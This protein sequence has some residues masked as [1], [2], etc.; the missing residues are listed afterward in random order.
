M[1]S[2]FNNRCCR[3][4]YPRWP[5][6]KNF[7][8]LSSVWPPIISMCVQLLF[9]ASRLK[10]SSC[11]WNC[12]S[13]LCKSLSFHMGLPETKHCTHILTSISSKPFNFAHSSLTPNDLLRCWKQDGREVLRTAQAQA[14]SLL[15]AVLGIQTEN[16]LTFSIIDSAGGS[17]SVHVQFSYFRCKTQQ[18]TAS[19]GGT[20]RARQRHWAQ[21][22]GQRLP[23][24]AGAI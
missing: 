14:L 20:Q 11:R 19:Q 12:S 21:C 22:A 23:A 9:F 2:P 5:L 4:W 18:H 10:L 6:W 8:A 7:Q 24:G 1:P 3:Y 15:A 16:Q 13:L 17:H